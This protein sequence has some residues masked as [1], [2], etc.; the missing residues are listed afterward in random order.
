M[1][2]IFQKW[3]GTWLEEIVSSHDTKKEE[4]EEHLAVLEAGQ[5]G[6]DAGGNWLQSMSHMTERQRRRRT[7]RLTEAGQKGPG[8]EC[9]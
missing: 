9:D 2:Q 6:S 5:E 4:A 8:P 7:R 3:P 1:M